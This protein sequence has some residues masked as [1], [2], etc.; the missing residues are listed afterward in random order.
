MPARRWRASSRRSRNSSSAA[1]TRRPT[2]PSSTL[3]STR[4]L[5]RLWPHITSYGGA[6]TEYRFSGLC[7]FSPGQ[8]RLESEI[9][10]LGLLGG[11]A[12][13]DM[14]K[15]TRR[16]ECRNR[17]E[18]ALSLQHIPDFPHSRRRLPGDDLSADKGEPGFRAGRPTAP[19]EIGGARVHVQR[20]FLRQV[21]ERSEIHQ[22]PA[23]RFIEHQAIIYPLRPARSDG[24]FAAFNYRHTRCVAPVGPRRG[25]SFFQQQIRRRFWVILQI[26]MPF[27]KWKGY[28]D[29][30]ALILISDE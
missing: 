18:H 11:A 12:Q 10:G 1:P 25:R 19:R 5:M 20:H 3:P 17:R 6:M 14:V 4:R 28:D 9:R 15:K 24:N 7:R 29:Y 21:H 8:Y 30:V 22:H 26:G 27:P 13:L 16:A 23:L 2:R